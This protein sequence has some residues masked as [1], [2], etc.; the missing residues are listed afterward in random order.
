MDEWTDG[1]MDGWTDGWVGGWMKGKYSKGNKNQAENYIRLWKQASK[2]RKV[3]KSILPCD[4]N[5]TFSLTYRP[6]RDR[7]TLKLLCGSRILVPLAL[8]S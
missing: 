7:G 2:T 4:G 1:Q 3:C 6:N 5:T 8:R